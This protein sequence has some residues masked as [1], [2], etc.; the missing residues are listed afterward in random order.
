MIGVA[1]AFIV[2]GVVFLFIVPWVGI[3]VGIVGLALAIIWIAGFGRRAA[4]RDEP[5]ERP[6]A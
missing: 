1:I 4:E 2:I 3:P 5:V 6:G